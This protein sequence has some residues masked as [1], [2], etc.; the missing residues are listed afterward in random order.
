MNSRTVDELIESIRNNNERILE[1]ISG[2]ELLVSSENII[3]KIW[4]SYTDIL[5][6]EN[7]VVKYLNILPGRKISN[8]RHSFRKETWIVLNGNGEAY[9][10]I[11]DSVLSM[12]ISSGSKFIVNVGTWHQVRANN[13]SGLIILEIQEGES[14]REDDIE[15]K[16]DVL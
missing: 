2:P 10:E 5:R 12:S 3:D 16:E 1:L 8:Q 15:R 6:K 4:G 14:C 11:G 7:I 13:D 9:L